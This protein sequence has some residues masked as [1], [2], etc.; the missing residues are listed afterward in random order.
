MAQA[1]KALAERLE[2][3]FRRYE[4]D[5]R[6]GGTDHQQREARIDWARARGHAQ[7][8]YQEDLRAARP[9]RERRTGLC[10]GCNR[11]VDLDGRKQLPAA[12]GDIRQ[13]WLTGIHRDQRGRRCPGSLRIVQPRVER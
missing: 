12:G 11:C 13:V 7:A 2:H 6:R 3:A 4:A 8:A 9:D 10:P 5:P 1:G